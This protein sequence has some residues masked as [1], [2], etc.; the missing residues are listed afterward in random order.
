M[1]DYRVLPVPAEFVGPS[2]EPHQVQLDGVVQRV[3]LFHGRADEELDWHVYFALRPEVA[4]RLG[5]HLRNNGESVAEGDVAVPYCELMVIDDWHRR[6]V[7]WPPWQASFQRK[8]DSAD[9]TRPLRLIKEGSNHAAYDLG[10]EVADEPGA[11]EDLSS[12]SRLFLHRGRVYMQ[13]LLVLDIGHSPA[14][15]EIH[16]PDSMAIAIGDGSQTL[17]ATETDTGW[18]ERF[19]RWRVAWF[20]NSAHHRINNEAPLKQQRTTTWFLSLPGDAKDTTFPPFL[21]QPHIEITT[22]PI[23]LWN[24]KDEEWYDR[25]GVAAIDDATLATDPRDNRRKLRV[26]ATMDVPGNRGG[27]VVRDYV[28]RV[29]PAIVDPVA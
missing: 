21:P 25:R 29:R 18:P 5:Q 11:N 2:G 7:T 3:T 13:G 8:Y 12:S 19:V 26:S 27:L 17:A 22:E 10:R 16:P 23:Q 1:S 28:V 20:A 6:G 9:V 14:K 24:S 15:L 4:A